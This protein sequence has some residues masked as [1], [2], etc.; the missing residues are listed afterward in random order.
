MEGGA[1]GERDGWVWYGGEKTVGLCRDGYGCGYRRRI[2]DGSW[3]REGV[4][5]FETRVKLGVVW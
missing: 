4:V 1:Q 5:G 2:Y 3:E